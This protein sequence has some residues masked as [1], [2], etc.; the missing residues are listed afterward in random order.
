MTKS[1]YILLSYEKIMWKRHGITEGS[2][3]LYPLKWYINT[4]RASADYVHRL[5]DA[6]SKDIV[7][8]LE[9]GGSVE[10]VCR[11]IKDYLYK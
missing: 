9:A 10:D 4:G 3:L 8:I 6:K 7:A 1:E 11:G 2:N 5:A